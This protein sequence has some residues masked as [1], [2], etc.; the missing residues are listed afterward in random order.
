MS[1]SFE[2]SIEISEQYDFTNE[3]LTENIEQ[4]TWVKNQWPLVYFIQN[5]S[6]KPKKIGYIGESTNASKRIKNHLANPKRQATILTPDFTNETYWC[7][8]GSGN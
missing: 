6:V 4:N 8:L 1:I 5:E 3:S 2:L 7:F